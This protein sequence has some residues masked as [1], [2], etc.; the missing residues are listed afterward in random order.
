MII[1]TEVYSQEK[2][3]ATIQWEKIATLENSDGSRSIGLA[4]AINAVNNHALVIAGGANFPDKMPWEGGKKQ[5]SDEI[6][7]LQQLDSKY[8]W[9]K[10][11]R[12]KF[13]MI[14]VNVKNTLMAACFHF[15]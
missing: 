10:K 1:N 7:I 6:H 14:V 15:L 2:A 5:Y 8:V 4:G 11:A 13:T 3:I 9:N 12:A